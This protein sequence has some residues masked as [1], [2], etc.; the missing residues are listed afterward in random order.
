MRATTR[1]LWDEQDKH[2]GDRRQLF[3][4]V[5]DLDVRTVL[6]PGSFVDISASLVFP[7]VT[8]V[9]INDR[10]R[11]F[12]EDEEGVAEIV[13]SYDEA[14]SDSR[15]EFVH[16]DYTTDLGLDDESFDLLVSLYAGFVS[17]A[18]G[19]YLR[20]GGHLLVNPSHGDV[21]MA[22]VDPR[23]RLAGVIQSGGAD[24]YR[25][26]SDDLDQYLI[27]KSGQGLT[28]EEIEQRGRGVAYTHSAFAYLFERA[29]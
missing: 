14:P 7:S 27:P 4:S 26:R 6:Y 16:A 5:S 12:F 24:G 29:S 22:S 3:A 20:V 17:R 19:R 25:L 23:F 28:V 21:A 2:P 13:A 18:C 9:D 8:Y 10:A 15:I 1:R 11:R